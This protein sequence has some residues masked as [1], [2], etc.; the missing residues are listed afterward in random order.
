[1][2]EVYIGG[3]PQ[4]LEGEWPVLWGGGKVLA[5]ANRSG[6]WTGLKSTT[7]GGNYG[8]WDEPGAGLGEQERSRGYSGQGFTYAPSHLDTQKDTVGTA[9][10]RCSVSSFLTVDSLEKDR[11]Y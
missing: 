5:I 9:P 6:Q 11:I 7:A 4:S 1:M 10:R 8:T 3:L 2:A